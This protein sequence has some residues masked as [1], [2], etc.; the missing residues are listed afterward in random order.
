MNVQVLLSLEQH[1]TSYTYN[2]NLVI[3]LPLTKNR[4][5]LFLHNAQRQ[6]PQQQR[7]IDMHE[8]IYNK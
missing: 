4:L 8:S 5:I 7:E 3:L 1:Q 6:L 2:R